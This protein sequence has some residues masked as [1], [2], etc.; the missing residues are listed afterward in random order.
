MAEIERCSECNVPVQAVTN[1]AWLAGGIIVQ[2]NDRDHRMVIIESENLDPLYKGIEEGLKVEAA[3]SK[4][5][6]SSKDAIEGFT[7]FMQ[8]RKPEFKGE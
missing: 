5:C 8:K 2:S 3:G 4:V 6:A 7:A 1:H